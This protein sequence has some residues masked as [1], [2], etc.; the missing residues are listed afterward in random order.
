[1]RFGIH[2]SSWL[3]LIE[4]YQDAGVDLLINGDRQHDVETREPFVSD[5]MPHYA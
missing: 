1:M 4:Q 5:V 2:N 3:D